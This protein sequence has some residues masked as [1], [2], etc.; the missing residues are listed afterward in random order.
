MEPGHYTGYWLSV[1]SNW[2]YVNPE[3]AIFVDIVN[4]NVNFQY[5]KVVVVFTK[6]ENGGQAKIQKD[7]DQPIYGECGIYAGEIFVS[8]CV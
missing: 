6:P 8:Y 1:F 2:P 3:P 4:S 7:G 5:L